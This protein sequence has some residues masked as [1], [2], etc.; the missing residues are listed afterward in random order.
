[1]SKSLDI[2]IKDE[3]SDSQ[4][5]IEN[6]ELLQ[7]DIKEESKE[8]LEYLESEGQLDVLNS[9]NTQLDVDEALRSHL[10]GLTNN[11]WMAGDELDYLGELKVEFEILP[12][13]ST[14]CLK[15]YVK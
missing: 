12:K 8:Y 15:N 4:T 10:Q 5:I 1:M 11:D 9:Q 3:P 2:D 7:T 13:F 14:G 6:V